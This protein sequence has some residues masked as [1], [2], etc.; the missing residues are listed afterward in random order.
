MSRV[1]IQ[2]NAIVHNDGSSDRTTMTFDYDTTISQTDQSDGRSMSIAGNIVP[3][4]DDTFQL[5]TGAKRW[6][7]IFQTGGSV[8]MGDDG[9]LTVSKGKM[10]IRNRKDGNLFPP[11]LWHQ[12][13]ALFKYGIQ[14]SVQQD[15]IARKTRNYIGTI[16]YDEKAGTFTDDTTDTLTIQDT[17]NTAETEQNDFYKDWYIDTTGTVG[18][19]S[20]RIYAK[21][22]GYTAS[23]KT[24]SVVN[25]FSDS[26][27]STGVTVTAI[28]TGTLFNLKSPAAYSSRTQK[29]LD[30]SQISGTIDSI[31]SQTEYV[32]SA[33]SG[34]LSSTN[35]KYNKIYIIKVTQS[36]TDYYAKVTDWVASS[37]S[38]KVKSS[39]PWYTDVSLN[40]VSTQPTIAAS[41]TFILIATK[42]RL[43]DLNIENMLNMLETDVPN[44]QDYKKY[45]AFGGDLSSSDTSFTIDASTPWDD[46]NTYDQ[47][48]KIISTYDITT[49]EFKSGTAIDIYSGGYN[50]GTGFSTTAIGE[51]ST[52][53]NVTISQASITTGA[54]NTFEVILPSNDAN[55]LSPS[56]DYTDYELQLKDTSGAI[57]YHTVVRSES[58]TVSSVAHVKITISYPFF[59]SPT[60]SHQY[61][62]AGFVNAYEVSGGDTGY[63]ASDQSTNVTSLNY[64]VVL[65][66]DAVSTDDYYNGYQITVEVYDSS[67]Y[68]TNSIRGTVTDYN[69]ST[70]V[71]TLSQSTYGSGIQ[72][73][74]GGSQATV[75]PGTAGYDYYKLVESGGSAD[76]Q[77]SY[78]TGG[79][80]VYDP[81]KTFQDASYGNLTA[82]TSAGMDTELYK[83]MKT[84]ENDADALNFDQFDASTSIAYNWSDYFFDNKSWFASSNSMYSAENVVIGSS[85]PPTGTLHNK[86]QVLGSINARSI[87]SA[88]SNTTSNNIKKITDDYRNKGYIFS[89]G[90]YI[91]NQNLSSIAL[92]S[93][94]INLSDGGLVVKGPA[95]FISGM[96]TGTLSIAGGIITDTTGEISFGDENLTTTGQL[97]AAQYNMNSDRNLKKDIEELTDDFDKFL[98]LNPVSFKWKNEFSEN[99]NT[100]Y[101]IIAQEVEKIYP[102]LVDKDTKSN[103]TVNYIGLIPLMLSHMQ[104]MHAMIQKLV[105]K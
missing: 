57:E 31:T 58:V 24:L 72:W 9:L 68:T 16:Q 26:S 1:R 64:Q 78:Y 55:S 12:K 56:A 85:A 90:L 40:F 87:L 98:Q 95:S 75:I 51:S 18:G 20:T 35:D 71:I 70:K 10:V 54:Y 65:G 13:H 23:T 76:Y 25:W 97:T 41:N 4:T 82:A 52:F 42:I 30:E 88:P 14:T 79:T 22:A 34:T 94:D 32:L 62:L 19:S 67:N 11:P 28:V 43:V 89:K 59:S 33:S 5:G 27:L 73:S 44:A 48:G 105:E 61:V 77:S 96:T 60:T 69:G 101:G 92:R 104:K 21:I 53:R 46:Y 45:N 36:G 38:V 66:V 83:Y 47:E 84:I 86:L 6:S 50:E 99:E 81:V 39:N 103:L 102:N 63:T 17:S 93:S 91:G 74:N 15:E 80:I 8:Y 29:F 3:T 49:N 100:Q 7:H 2:N 37:N